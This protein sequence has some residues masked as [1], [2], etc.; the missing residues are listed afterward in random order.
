VKA[1]DPYGGT[2]KKSVAVTVCP[3]V[4]ELIT[5]SEKNGTVPMQLNVR[6]PGGTIVNSVSLNSSTLKGVSTMTAMPIAFTQLEQR[7]M[8]TVQLKFQGVPSGPATLIVHGTSS[9][10][11]VCTNTTVPVP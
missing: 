6:N 8:K 9:A 3:I 10:G 5:L 2:D 7:V 11:P 1:T 4:I